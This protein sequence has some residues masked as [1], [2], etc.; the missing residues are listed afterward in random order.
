MKNDEFFMQIALKEAELCIE[1]DVLP[2]AALVTLN[3]HI[4]AISR[5]TKEGNSRLDHAEKLV[6]EK[7]LK[8][9]KKAEQLTLYTTLEPCIKC[10]GEILNSRLSRVV[11]ALEDSYG[12]ASCILKYD[13]LP[14]RHQ[15]EFPGL[16]G[17]VLRSESKQIF[18]RF[19]ETTSSEFWQNKDNPL[20]RV[21]F[22]D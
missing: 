8:G 13:R 2:V 17:G 12:G 5:K 15:N 21:C 22:E 11:Y 20:V 10:M 4:L 18:R 16:K 6:L 7:V 19:L 3:N 9:R 1:E 14:T